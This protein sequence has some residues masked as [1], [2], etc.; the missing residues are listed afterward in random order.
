MPR[1]YNHF[2]TNRNKQNNVRY[3]R[4]GIA[5]DLGSRTALLDFK[6][7]QATSPLTVSIWFLKVKD[8]IASVCPKYGLKNIVNANGTVGEYPV[9][10]PPA[11]P[12]DLDNFVDTTLWKA[13]VSSQEI[14]VRELSQDKKTAANAI[15]DLIGENSR[16]R[17]EEYNEGMDDDDRY[18]L[19]DAI[20]LLKA[21][22][23]THFSDWRIDNSMK[24]SIAQK[25]Y[26]NISMTSEENLVSYHRRW[27]VLKDAYSKALDEDEFNAAN[28]EVLLGHN[29]DQVVRFI[30]SL[31][32]N[33]Y[34]SLISNYRTM[35]RE[36]PDSVLSA[37]NEAHIWIDNQV[38]NY[39]R[40]IF[41][42]TPASQEV[43]TADHSKICHR[44]GSSGHLQNNCNNVLARDN[45]DGGRSTGRGGR[46]GRG[47]GARGGR[48]RGGSAKPSSSE[49]SEN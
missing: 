13:R 29:H 48:G 14:I 34:G 22:A 20:D 37:Y 30:S 41:V 40:G 31:D 28:I 32:L 44:C 11:A 19:D 10:D 15:W 4:N 5:Q 43:R 26:I 33:R 21:V 7:G 45:P 36:W 46:G 49:K 18:D 35:Q 24:T 6:P 3:Q 16:F 25:A 1:G 17:I 8:V 39:K 2:R 42:I 27:N 9:F 38:T 23:K 47:R 12:A